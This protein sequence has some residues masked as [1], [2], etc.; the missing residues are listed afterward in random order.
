MRISVLCFELRTSYVSRISVWSS[1]V[2]SSDLCAERH[3]A[4]VDDLGSALAFN[5]GF[6]RFHA[7]LSCS[8]VHLVGR[9]EERKGKSL[10]NTVIARSRMRRGNLQLSALRKV[11]G[12]SLIFYAPYARLLLRPPRAAFAVVLGLLAFV[13]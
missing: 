9:R 1:D 3:L 11:D 5:K 6:D 4:P 12:W 10:I 7:R 2:C 13:S 8:P